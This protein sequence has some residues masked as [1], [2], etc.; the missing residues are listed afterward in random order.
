MS[1]T[2]DDREDDVVLAA[3][4]VL[5]LLSGEA[6]R[7]AQVRSR[8]DP[9]FADLIVFWQE[10]LATLFEDNAPA[11]PPAALKRKIDARLFG[12]SRGARR[13]RASLGPLV[14]AAVTGF[15]AAL[16]L[17][18]AVTTSIWP[19]DNADALIAVATSPDAPA[20]AI[21][22]FDRDASALRVRTR[23]VAAGPDQSLELWLI[24]E[25]E[26]PT[27]LGLLEPDGASDIAVSVA[28][29]AR[30]REAGALAVSVE[31]F[32]GSP[33]GAPTGPVVAVGPIRAVS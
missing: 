32:G 22:E 28:M 33:T 9:A 21:V 1:Q 30:L 15:A 23:N 31:P 27:S 2:S 6:F 25:G 10:Q 16:A 17:A 14:L 5:G 19:R 12:A 26:G 13:S 7:E 3:E 4:F 24:P 29:A 18:L 8:S 11:A 20:T